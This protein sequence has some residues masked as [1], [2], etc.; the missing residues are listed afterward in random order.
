M[1]VDRDLSLKLRFK[2][3]LFQMGYY[4]PIEVELSQYEA[5]YEELKRQSLTDL[6]VLGLKFD[7][8]FT[9][10][11]VVGD[12]KT[13][14]RVSD[15]NRLFW[16]RGVMDYF[17]AN[18]GYYL[19]PVI[20]RQAKAIAPRLGITT[21]DENGL[22]AL[23]KDLDAN[24]L[25]LPLQDLGFYE[26]Q[27]KQWGIF[28]PKGTK[29]ASR[30][31]DLKKVYTYLSYSYWYFEQHRNL[32][33]L[34]AHFQKI[35]HLLNPMDPRDI[36][37][38]H[39]GVERFALSLLQMASDIYLRGLSDIPLNARVYLYGGAFAVRDR[40]EYFK[41]LNKLTGANEP[42]DPP[43]LDDTIELL[44][45]IVHNP[46]AATEVLRYLEAIYGW[47][48]QL[49][50]KDVTALFGAKMQTSA[51]VL[52]RDI[53]ITFT[54]ATGMREQIFSKILSL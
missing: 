53:A 22:M 44:N 23:E 51:V 5:L 32:F 42:L 14:R 46:Y 31:L 26:M 49:G 7:V 13:G 36:L 35:A 38:A 19:R 41:L 45:R 20:D 48:V 11:K 29:P 47:C 12:C 10:N 39:V 18:T 43:F 27:R 16:L 28:I 37:L 9:A 24:T 33:L 2:R 6:D 4:S 50:N 40:Q 34:V 3:V 52:A 1:L 25:P 30:E 15:I 17:G 54:K 21:L 8:A